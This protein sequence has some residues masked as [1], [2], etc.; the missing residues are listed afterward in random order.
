MCVAPPAPPQ[1]PGLHGGFA[2]KCL[3][4]IVAEENKTLCSIDSWRCQ[5][6]SEVGVVVVGGGEPSLFQLK[7]RQR[8]ERNGCQAK[9]QSKEA[10]NHQY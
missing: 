9:V 4:F 6:D 3:E 7:T 2:V 8:R 5:G 1:M 10:I